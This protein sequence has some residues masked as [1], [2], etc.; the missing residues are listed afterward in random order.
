M[1]KEIT[2]KITVKGPLG[3]VWKKWT[4]PVHI[5]NWNH[6]N[7]DWYCPSAQNDLQPGGEFHYM[8]AARDGSVK[9]D[10]NGTYECIDPEKTIIYFIDDGR[11]VV[12]SFKQEEDNVRIIE[13]IEPEEVNSFEIQRSG[14][15]LILDNFKKYS[16]TELTSN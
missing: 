16:E 5:V 4:D 15:Q 12:V 3:E 2:V 10:F 13:T 9:F 11:K 14:W 8:M 1:E 7:E 6:A